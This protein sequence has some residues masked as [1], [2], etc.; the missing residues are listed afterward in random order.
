MGFLGSI[1]NAL[2][3]RRQLEGIFAYR[4]KALKKRFPVIN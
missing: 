3:I 4:E 2:F 1:A